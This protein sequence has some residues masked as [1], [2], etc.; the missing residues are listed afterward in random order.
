MER[1]RTEERTCLLE[2]TCELFCIF[3]DRLGLCKLL[4]VAHKL[5]HDAFNFSQEHN[6]MLNIIWK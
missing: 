3:I 5:P 6:T 1:R 2:M 4:F